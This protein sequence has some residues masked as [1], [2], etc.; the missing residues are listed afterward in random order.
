MR[1]LPV[2][3]GS[4]AGD[5]PFDW[6]D[7]STW[8]DALHGAGSAYVTFVPD[9]AFPGA[10]DK[11]GAFATVA[12]GLG[13]R[14][15]VLLS[16]RGEEGALASER[17]LQD[18]GVDWTVVRSAWFAQN[19]SEDFLVGSVLDGVISLPAAQVAEPFIDAEDIADVAVG[20]LTD[21]R[22]VGQVYEVTG[23]RLMTFA[24]VADELSRAAGRPIRYEPITADEFVAAAMAQ[25][26]AADDAAALAGLFTAVLDGRNAGLTDGVERAL[27]RPARDFRDYARA[28]A[29]TGVWDVPMTSV[30]SLDRT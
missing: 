20:A 8:P 21:D 15:L 2:R 3:I 25:G 12:L 19:F 29:A 16:G 17:A 9:L 6:D 30:A 4:R 7:E 27:G 5:P 14:R 26:M 1:G 23:P 22:H 28:A 18:S 13:V 10:P 24:D 11:V